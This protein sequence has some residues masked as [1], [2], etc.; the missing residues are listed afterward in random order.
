MRRSSAERCAPT[1]RRAAL[2][3]DRPGLGRA[4]SPRTDPRSAPEGGGGR[5][6][7][8][9]GQE[10]RC[11]PP[12][13]PRPAS[14]G[15]AG[16]SAGLAG[17]AHAASY[18]RA[19][20]VRIFGKEPPEGS[21][22]STRV[23]PLTV[24]DETLARVALE[25]SPAGRYKRLGRGARHFPHRVGADVGEGPRGGLRAEVPGLENRGIYDVGLSIARTLD[26]ESLCR[27]ILMKSVSLLNA[28]SGRSSSAPAAPAGPWRERR[29]RPELRDPARSS[30]K[31]VEEPDGAVLV[32]NRREDRHSVARERARRRSS[33]DPDLLGGASLRAPRRRRQGEPAGGSTTS[34]RPT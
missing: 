12:P 15:L 10:P 14:V 3:D 29:L 31:P 4:G 18:D 24:G 17:S 30:R 23:V 28:R 21:R 20:L 26:L 27:R 22:R 6:R 16:L 2:L 9:L 33:G 5:P 13:G 32:C 8:R 11:H 7:P 19:L 1:S 25:R 34:G